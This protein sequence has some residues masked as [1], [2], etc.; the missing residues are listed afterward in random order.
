MGDI[1]VAADI[2]CWAAVTW[3]CAEVAAAA[4]D[5]QHGGVFSIQRIW[6]YDLGTR[7]SAAEVGDPQVGSEQVR[8]VAQQF[9]SVQGAGNAVI[10]AVFEVAK[11]NCRG[12]RQ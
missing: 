9:R 6:L 10:P 7:V 5:P 4:F 1:S 11:C 3:P 8:P 12:H 2:A